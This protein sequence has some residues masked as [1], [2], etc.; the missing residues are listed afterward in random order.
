MLIDRILTSTLLT[1]AALA[2]VACSPASEADVTPQGGEAPADAAPGPAPSVSLPEVGQ[3]Y[4]AARRQLLAAGFE[5]VVI[6]DAEPFSVCVAEMEAAEVLSGDC[7][8]EPMVLPE[9]EGCAGTGMG[10]C[11]T[12]W[13]QRDTGRELSVFTTGEPQPGV[14]SGVEWIEAGIQPVI[15]TEAACRQAIEAQFG[16]SGPAVTF[17]GGAI[18][19]RAPVDGGR[20]SFDCAVDGDTVSLTREGQTQTYTLN[21]AADDAAEEEAR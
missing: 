19:W 9:V 1:A 4:W 16:Q 5:P 8:G 2:A 20:M 18:S 11:R 7:P 14:V 13:R 17:V 12:N 10:D 15:S 21:A 3:A 6:E